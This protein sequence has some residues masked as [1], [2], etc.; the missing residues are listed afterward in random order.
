LLD[1]TRERRLYH[2]CGPLNPLGDIVA[3]STHSNLHVK[4]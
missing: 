1:L 2:R 3:Q 4:M